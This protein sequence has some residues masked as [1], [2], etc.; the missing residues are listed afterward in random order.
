MSELE[1]QEHHHNMDITPAVAAPIQS[2]SKISPPL[3]YCKQPGHLAF[4]CPR[5]K[6]STKPNTQHRDSTSKRYTDYRHDSVN[7]HYPRRT[8][9]PSQRKSSFC[10]IHGAYSHHTDK[11]FTGKKLR[12]EYPRHG[13][14]QSSPLVKKKK[15]K[16]SYPNSAKRVNKMKI[17][18]E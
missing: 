2:A 18:T 6:D 13:R 14:T 16:K 5:R 9:S 17:K 15:K 3:H 8:Y 1:Q 10:L 7:S 4:N 12:D 11:C